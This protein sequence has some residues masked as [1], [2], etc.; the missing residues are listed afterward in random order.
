MRTF[1][2]EAG[3]TPG[4]EL[5]SVLMG[6]NSNQ[7]K[8]D[9]C[10]AQVVTMGAGSGGEVT[11]LVLGPK[12]AFKAGLETVGERTPLTMETTMVDGEKYD[13][14]EHW[15]RMM[16]WRPK[17]GPPSDGHAEAALLA[18]LQRR[19]ESRGPR[20][21]P[22]AVEALC[23]E[24]FGKHLD[25]LHAILKGSGEMQEQV[26]GVTVAVM[27]PVD[28][29]ELAELLAR[30]P[31]EWMPV[32]QES[33]GWKTAHWND[34]GDVEAAQAK[35]RREGRRS[36]YKAAGLLGLGTATGFLANYLWRSLGSSQR[37]AA[38]G[39]FVLP[40]TIAK[41]SAEVPGGRTWTYVWSVG[42]PKPPAP[43][44][45]GALC[46]DQVCTNFGSPWAVTYPLAWNMTSW[47]AADTCRTLCNSPQDTENLRDERLL[48]H[49]PLTRTPTTMSHEEQVQQFSAALT[50]VCSGRSGPL[51]NV[52]TIL[53]CD[54]DVAD[55]TCDVLTKSTQEIQKVTLTD[56]ETSVVR[57]ANSFADYPKDVYDV[58]NCNFECWNL[59]E[60]AKQTAIANRAAE[61]A[62]RNSLKPTKKTHQLHLRF[63]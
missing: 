51:R 1:K 11:A 7:T 16:V 30:V 38:V 54:C 45:S 52:G 44:G 47:V 17:D 12:T 63:G 18:A 9:G 37:G 31:K 29:S 56:L 3:G 33:A 27:R 13:W 6:P 60:K 34:G 39:D 59:T 53:P 14:F 40:G 55:V 42:D 19:L 15:D 57:V 2:S 22:E 26:D 20:D 4:S 36:L 58:T 46:C 62:R 21:K 43:C 5:L 8:L 48:T 41:L 24:V 32:L 50:R 49:F 10:V 61:A 25:D 35:P 28:P 23:R